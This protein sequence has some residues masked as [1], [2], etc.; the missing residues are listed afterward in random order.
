[1][2]AKENAQQNPIRSISVL[3]ENDQHSSDD[4][5][6]V[7]ATNDITLKHCDICDGAGQLDW[8][9]TVMFEGKSISCGEFGWIF[10]SKNILDGSDKCLDYRSSYFG[11]CCFVPPSNGCSLCDGK[12]GEWYDINLVATTAYDGESEVSCTQLSN[13]IS[14]KIESSS[15]QCTEAKNDHFDTCCFQKCSICGDL[16][17]DWEATIFYNGSEVSCHQLE[18]KVFYE[19]G[20]GMTSDTCVTSQELYKSA[21][22]IDPPQNPCNLCRS[23]DNEFRLK[24]EVNVVS[25]TGETESCLEVFQTLLSRREQSS[26]QCLSAQNELQSKCCDRTYDY[27]APVPTPAIN[28]SPSAMDEPAGYPHDG[29]YYTKPD[30]NE[31]W[32]GSGRNRIA[33]TVKVCLLG[34]TA[35]VLII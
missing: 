17:M 30:W 19:K 10:G 23:G 14:R 1:M 22:C 26:Q 18:G 21:C 29:F 20:I 16:Q 15:T 7:E 8:S 12:G 31:N 35:W 2:P 4:S 25:A 3:N 27:N 24:S 28:W 32:N 6:T 13:K 5:Q 34:M 11:Q 9:E 33:S